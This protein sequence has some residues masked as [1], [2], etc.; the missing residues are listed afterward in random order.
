MAKA[1]DLGWPN[2]SHGRGEARCMLTGKRGRFSY[3]FRT[4]G[5]MVLTCCA[6]LS[7]AQQRPKTKL[8]ELPSLL[9]KP[10]PPF[11][12]TTLA[13]KQ[14]SLAEYKGKAVIVNFWATWCGSCRVEMPWLAQLREKY[15]SQG[16]EILGIVTDNAT[17]TK[18]SELAQKYGV[19]YPNL[20]C[21]H[22]TAQ[23]YGGLPELP[24][25]FFIDRRGIVVAEMNGADS[26]RQ[27]EA[28]IRRALKRPWR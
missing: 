4:L 6:F 23:A 15:T 13:G 11:V 7:Q 5:M 9:G 10:A 2:S 17:A 19:H 16:F 22:K 14:V 12:V 21:N 24:T 27:I 26:E 20:M 1:V 3:G 18:I 25:S 28:N 8:E